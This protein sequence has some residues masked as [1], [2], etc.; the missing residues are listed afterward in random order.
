MDDK[1][2]TLIEEIR[3][4]LDTLTAQA[5]Q[6]ADLPTERWPKEQW[7]VGQ[8]EKQK[9]AAPPRIEW[10]EQ[11]GSIED[12]RSVGDNDGSI[13][14]DAARYLVTVWHASVGESRRTLHNLMLAIRNVALGP[15]VVFG[16]YAWVD[17]ANTK[18]GR[19]VAIR[20][21]LRIPVP[22]E[23]M[24]SATTMSQ[25]HQVSLNDQIVC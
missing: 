3:V 6:L 24:P 15:N 23:V 1:F 2:E 21:T 10:E 12:S 14:T 4:E 11:D 18:K 8:L 13:Y 19:K 20:V 17:D 16:D 9:N 22:A 5:A 25:D 7:A